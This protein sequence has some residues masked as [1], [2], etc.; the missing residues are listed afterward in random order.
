MSIYS[1]IYC[2]C[3]IC[4]EVRP[5]KGIHSHY[6]ASHTEEGRKRIKENGILYGK[7][8]GDTFKTKYQSKKEAAVHQYNLSPNTCKHCNSILDFDKKINKFCSQ[9]CSA[10]HNNTQLKGT[11]KGRKFSQTALDNIR[12]ANLVRS[13]VAGDYCRIYRCRKCQ[14]Y[15]PSTEQKHLCCKD[16]STAYRPLCKFS[17]NLGDYPEEFDLSLIEKHGM[18]SPTKNPTGVSRDHMVSIDYAFKHKIDPSIIRH[19][20][21]CRIILQKDNSQKHTKSEISLD[22]LLERISDWD[23]KYQSNM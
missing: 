23:I 16:S 17:F 20:A 4:K 15:H 1:T 2:S 9:S 13:V 19:P 8:G 18:F 6:A 21:N 7:L 11:R 12:N 3:I 5:S 14:K 10:T 22:E